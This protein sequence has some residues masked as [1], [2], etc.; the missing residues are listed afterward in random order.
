MWWRCAA[1]MVKRTRAQTRDMARTRARKAARSL[2]G[3]MRAFP[4]S[5]KTA[6]SQAASTPSWLAAGGGAGA[7]LLGV[8]GH[9]LVPARPALCSLA[10][11]TRPLKGLD[12]VRVRCRVSAFHPG[13]A[14]P[15]VC[16]DGEVL[17]RTYG[18]SGIVVFNMSRLV[19]PGDELALDFLPEMGEGDVKALLAQR[20][21]GLGVCGAAGGDAAGATDG[22]ASVPPPVLADLMRGIFATRINDAVLRMAGLSPDTALARASRAGAD[23]PWERIAHAVKD[24]RLAV[25]GPGD[26]QRAQV[27]RG[28]ARTDGFDP[29]TMASRLHPGLFA[30]GEVLDVD[31]PCGGWNLHWAWA[32]GIAAGASA[33]ARV[34]AG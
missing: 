4:S 12:G 29:R 18:V 1:R 15:F 11:E 20:A 9:A 23:G 30:C 17:F 3:R 6:R 25:K 19:S 26:A 14:A 32:S 31:G 27:T 21:H 22:D 5:W 10:C 8:C 28:G 34:P 33:A 2:M 13:D 7:Q 24:F 16:E